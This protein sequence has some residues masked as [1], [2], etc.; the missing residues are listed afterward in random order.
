[1]EEEKSSLSTFSHLTCDFFYYSDLPFPLPPA[2]P[3]ATGSLLPPPG[4]GSSPGPRPALKRHRRWWRGAGCGPAVSARS[5]PVIA[6]RPCCGSPPPRRASPAPP[7][8]LSPPRP[9]A[10]AG[11]GRGCGRRWWWGCWPPSSPGCGT[12]EGTGEERRAAR[13]PRRR[14][15]KRRQQVP[16]GDAAGM[17]PGVG[18][19]RCARAGRGRLGC[20]AAEL[21]CAA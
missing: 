11:C 8:P 15:A 2:P 3:G 19:S 10:G 9:A 18:V 7:P 14:G 6:A 17:E 1:M 21:L 20:A 12:A 13:G 4:S 5:W 16:G